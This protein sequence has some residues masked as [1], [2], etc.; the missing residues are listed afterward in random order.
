[1]KKMLMLG[2]LLAITS[3]AGQRVVVAEE[4]TATT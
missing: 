3:Y 1:M 2:L 4:F